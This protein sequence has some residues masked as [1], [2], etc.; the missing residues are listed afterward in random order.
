MKNG[1]SYNAGHFDLEKNAA[2]AYDRKAEELFGEFAVLNFPM[3]KD[4]PIPRTRQS[5]RKPIKL[6]LK[7]VIIIKKLL[8]QNITIQ[9]VAKKFNVSVQTIRDIK[10]G[11]RWGNV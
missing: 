10:R 9:Y 2:L 3:K 5:P 6:S 11:R 4:I 8:L 1:R 7:Q